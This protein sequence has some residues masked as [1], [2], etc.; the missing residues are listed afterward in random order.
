F[1][2]ETPCMTPAGPQ[3]VQLFLR[4]G[5]AEVVDNWHVTGLRGTGSY[6]LRAEDVF[7]PAELS[8]A[9]SMP[10]GPRPLRDSALSR[11][12]LMSLLAMVQAAPV[13][14]GIARRAIDEFK[15]LAIGKKNPMGP[16]LSDQVQSHVGLARAEA[17]LGSARAY[18]YSEVQGMWDTAVD[19]RQIS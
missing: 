12:P 17:L 11:F 8:G 4:P 15:A 18:Y 13:S 5:D 6:D 16:G 10:A 3:M 7:V 2:G 1:D 9:F 14:L 19:G